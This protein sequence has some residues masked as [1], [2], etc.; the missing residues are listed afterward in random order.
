M[1]SGC[2]EKATPRLA[3]VEA[4]ESRSRHCYIRVAGAHLGPSP[5]YSVSFDLFCGSFDFVQ[6]TWAVTWSL[7]DISWLREYRDRD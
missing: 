3:H 2:Y 7:S 1:A 6:A 4:L 5:L